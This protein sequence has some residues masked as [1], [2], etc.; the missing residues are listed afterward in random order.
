VI[1]LDK[2]RERER[3]REKDRSIDEEERKPQRR[4]PEPLTKKQL[5]HISLRRRNGTNDATD[6]LRVRGIREFSLA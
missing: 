1:P 3:E 4:P 5:R 6:Y 2:A